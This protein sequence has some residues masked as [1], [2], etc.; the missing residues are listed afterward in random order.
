MAR[1]N[2]PQRS[3][4]AA[5]TRAP[6]PIVEPLRQEVTPSR[7]ALVA[8]VL[9]IIAAAVIRIV[10]ARDEFWMDEIWTLLSL[11]RFV[12]S[13]LDVF[14]QHHDN[15]HY[16]MTLWMYLVAPQR[17]W[18]IYRLPSLIA[19][20]A[21]VVLAVQYA[22]R[23]GTF[24]AL[25]AALLTGISLVLVTFASEARGYAMAGCFALVALV[26][27]DRFIATRGL[28]ALAL[29]VTAIL[30]GISSHLTFLQFYFGAV[31]YS[32]VALWRSRE[33]HAHWALDLTK[34]HL[35]PLLFFAWL[36]AT[37][38]REMKF[39]GGDT[40][41]LRDVLARTCALAVGSL[42]GNGP[43]AILLGLGELAVTATTLV[44]LW[45]EKSDLWILVVAGFVVAPTL[46]FLLRSPEVLHERYF[47]LNILFFLILLSYFLARIFERGGW[48]RFAAPLVLT[49]II[50]ANVRA[51]IDFLRFGRGHFLD[52]LR[53]AAEHNDGPDVHLAGDTD[54]A[55]RMYAEFYTPYA[56]SEHKY[57]VHSFAE[58]PTFEPEWVIVSSQSHNYHPDRAIRDNTGR[59]AYLFQRV[60]RRGG[61]SGTNFAVYRKAPSVGT[62]A[63]S[64]SDQAP[65]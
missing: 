63:A 27:L 18:I 49:T 9:V 26:A 11:Q 15:N 41:V 19:G 5:A 20:I 57:T 40:Y 4:A 38:L 65:P 48:G 24:A 6:Q 31:V 64:R 61:I 35:I 36:Y 62:P 50:A 58:D 3:P 59:E 44:W 33:S 2:S 55:Y 45:R 56:P 60:F 23:W 29:F 34:L 39:G 7:N 53:F 14:R 13:P 22:R 37:D 43:W 46:V 8:I 30:L 47:Y 51:D 54:F 52:L 1:R 32:A 25:V 42:S 10:A 28:G 17:E 21:T 12:H 16:L